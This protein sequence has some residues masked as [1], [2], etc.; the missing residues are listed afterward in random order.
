MGLEG[1]PHGRPPSFDA[2]GRLL[3]VGTRGA[4]LDSTSSVQR[5]FKDEL[6]DGQTGASSG[7]SSGPSHW[8][9]FKPTLKG[10]IAAIAWCMTLWCG[11]VG[12]SFLRFLKVPFPPQLVS[13]DTEMGSHVGAPP[14]STQRDRLTDRNV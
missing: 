7:A 12:V 4:D 10:S 3:G 9:M 6:R 2:H 13:R 14:I 8:F 5:S 11:C 1:K